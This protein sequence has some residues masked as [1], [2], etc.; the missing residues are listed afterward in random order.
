MKFSAT[1]SERNQVRLTLR[2]DSVR[3]N[4][5]QGIEEIA[6]RNGWIDCAQLL[7]HAEALAK[8]GYGVYLHGLIR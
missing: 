8:S 5:D 1:N 4:A 7:V 3:R 6:W 2:A